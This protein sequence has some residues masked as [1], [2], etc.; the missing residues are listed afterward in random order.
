MHWHIVMFNKMLINSLFFHPYACS[1]IFLQPT[2]LLY[3]FLLSKLND[4]VYIQYVHTV[5]R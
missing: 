3:S 5:L 1:L 2:V 4:S